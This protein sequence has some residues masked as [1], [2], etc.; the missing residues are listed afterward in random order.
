MHLTFPPLFLALSLHPPPHPQ[1]FPKNLPE[2][3]KVGFTV[4]NQVWAA[5]SPVKNSPAD[6]AAKGAGGNPSHSAT[7]AELDWYETN[8]KVRRRPA[9][10]GWVEANR[11]EAAGRRLCAA[12]W[13]GDAAALGTLTLAGSRSA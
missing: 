13:G 1:D 2:G 3:S 5:Y 7:S 8:C 9:A 4:V 11:A 6:A 12:V 10:A